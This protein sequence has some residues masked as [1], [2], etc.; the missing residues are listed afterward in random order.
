M[1]KKQFKLFISV[2]SSILFLMYPLSISATIYEKQKPQNSATVFEKKV[3]IKQSFF[4]RI[5]QKIVQRKIENALK[6]Q[7][8]HNFEQEQ[9]NQTVGLLALAFMFVGAILLLLSSKIWILFILAGLILSVVGMI[10]E[11]KPTYARRT[12][13]VSLLLLLLYAVI[14]SRI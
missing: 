3:K 9:P 10:T 5:A 7:S 8:K 4:Q 6:K 1:L 12:F 2:L 11:E 14:G 13:I